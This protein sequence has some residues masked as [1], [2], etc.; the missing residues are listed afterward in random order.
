MEVLDKWWKTHGSAKITARRAK[1]SADN[2]L[3]GA[4]LTDGKP[5]GNRCHHSLLTKTHQARQTLTA[6]LLVACD[7]Q[8]RQTV[9]Y[10]ALS[11][12]AHDYHQVGVVGVVMTDK[13]TIIA[14]ERFNKMGAVAVLPLVDAFDIG[15]GMDDKPSKAT[16][17]LWC[18]CAQKGEEQRYLDDDQ[19]F[20]DTIQQAFGSPAGR[21]VKAGKRGAYPLVKI[22]ADSQVK[23][24]LRHHGQ[25]RPTL[26]PVAGQGFNLCMRDADT[27]ARCWHS[28]WCGKDI[29]DSSML[30]TYA[31]RRKVD[32]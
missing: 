24:S 30:Q 32:R 6:D 18:G 28:K 23:R 8:T 5:G 16:A 10:W 20:L 31:K 29:G 3:D 21:F 2:L 12:T 19:Y 25:C 13:T 14:I 27:L 11:A 15:Q 7:G 1:Q 9:N 17:A 4:T 22:L 26:H